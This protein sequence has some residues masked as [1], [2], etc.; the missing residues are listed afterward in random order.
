[1]KKNY[2]LYV[3][4]I[5]ILVF[6]LIE[7]VTPD[8]KI[9]DLE[10]RNLKTRVKFTMKGFIDGT[11]S[12]EYEEYVNDQFIGRNQWINLKFRSEY[13]LGKVENNGIIYGK[14]KYLF[15]KFNEVNEEKLEYSLSGINT[16]IKNRNENISFMIIPNSYEVYRDKLPIGTSVINQE[17]VIEEIYKA[18]KESNN[19]DLLSIMKNNK[20]D[21]IYYRNDHHW[22]TYGAYLAYKELIKSIDEIPVDINK[23]SKKSEDNFYGTYFS[24]SKAFNTISD[25]LDYYEFENI[26]MKIEDKIYE[27]LYDYSYLNTRDKYS[28]FL[29]GNNGLTIIKNKEL[30]NGKKIVVFKDSFGNSMIPFLT[31]NFDEIHVVDL[32]AFMMNVNNYMEDNDFDEVLIMYNLSNFLRETNI[33]K[34]KL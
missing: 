17:S 33:L 31:M 15:E 24:R 7:I 13:V 14:D 9:S 30:N 32:R 8:K 26:E 4:F 16:F 6:T 2:L 5:I 22:T 28:I 29:R 10:N 23:L 11:F 34:L 21:Y 3:F 18:V 12:K 27:N 1:L 20:E 25:V 19:I